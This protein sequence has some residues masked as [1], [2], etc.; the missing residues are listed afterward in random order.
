MATVLHDATPVNGRLADPATQ[1]PDRPIRH[2]PGFEWVNW[3]GTVYTFSSKQ[4]RVVAE[5]WKAREEG[6]HWV[7]RHA[8]FELA[9]SVCHNLRA[10]FAQGKHPAWGVIIVPAKGQ[11]APPGCYRLAALPVNF[12]EQEP[13]KPR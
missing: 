4:R 10:L 7:D 9:E 12:E 1:S 2:A 8:L 6:Y 11:D 3:C 13:R 5:L